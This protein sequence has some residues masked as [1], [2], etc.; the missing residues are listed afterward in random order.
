[1]DSSV[2][3]EPLQPGTVLSSVPRR[4]GDI[5]EDTGLGAEATQDLGFGAGR[6]GPWGWGRIHGRGCRLTR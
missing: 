6:H 5:L 4:E 1:M 3:S 2:K